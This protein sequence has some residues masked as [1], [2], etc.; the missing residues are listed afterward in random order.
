MIPLPVHL[1]MHLP[2]NRNVAHRDIYLIHIEKEIEIRRKRLL[3]KQQ[4][5]QPIVAQNRFLDKVKQDYAKY[6]AV[7]FQQKQEQLQALELLNQYIHDLQQSGKLSKQN[8]KDS[9]YEQKKII[10]ELKKIKK[11]LDELVQFNE[12]HF[13]ST[14]KKIVV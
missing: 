2:I 12:D 7:I 8:I 9:L 14:K 11:S 6:H 5:L 4:Q 3:E 13:L 10:A 1:P